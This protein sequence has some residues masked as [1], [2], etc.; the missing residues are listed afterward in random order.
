MA[1][2]DKL[3]QAIKERGLS[4]R[5]IANKIGLSEV[6]LSRKLHG[7]SEFTVSEANAIASVIQMSTKERNDIFFAKEVI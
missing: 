3:N 2:L 7:Q 1:N 6:V 4:Q 5:F